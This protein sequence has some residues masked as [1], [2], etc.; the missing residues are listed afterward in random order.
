M[1]G[2]FCRYSEKVFHLSEHIARATDQ[3]SGREKQIGGAWKGLRE[4]RDLRWAPCERAV[5]LHL[6]PP[7]DGSTLGFEL[8]LRLGRAF[9]P[10]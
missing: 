3:R 5:L 2:R 8:P 1:M 6:S 4:F 9:Q 7:V 10:L